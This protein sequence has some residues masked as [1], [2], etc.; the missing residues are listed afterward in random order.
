MLHSDYFNQTRA[1]GAIVKKDMADKGFKFAVSLALGE[2]GIVL[3]K[4]N[5]LDYLYEKG[6]V[7][8]RSNK[9]IDDILKGARKIRK[10]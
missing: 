8:R 1:V 10:E 2:S 9:N 4:E 6:Y 7:A 3:S 5:A